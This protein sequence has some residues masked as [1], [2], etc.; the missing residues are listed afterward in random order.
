[1]NF[2][3]ERTGDSEPTVELVT[4][5]SEPMMQLVTSDSMAVMQLVT[6]DSM[7]I[8]QLVTSD[9]MPIMQLVTGDS[10]PV[11]N[12]KKTSVKVG[13]TAPFLPFL[14]PVV[15]RRYLTHQTSE[16]VFIGF[17]FL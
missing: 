3:C 7:P 17:S 12:N 9:S 2:P 5:N 10:L 1:M 8:M 16:R 11:R 6:S 13:L 14:Q 15:Q 4:G